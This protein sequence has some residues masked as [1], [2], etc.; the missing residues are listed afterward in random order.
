MMNVVQRY[1]VQVGGQFTHRSTY[2][3]QN[4]HSRRT[5]RRTSTSRL[6]KRNV[7][8]TLARGLPLSTSRVLVRGKWSAPNQRCNSMPCHALWYAVVSPFVA[9]RSR[10]TPLS[11]DT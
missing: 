5:S 1:E 6:P 11:S 2:N 9:D 8:V 4:D 3:L 7:T 10:L